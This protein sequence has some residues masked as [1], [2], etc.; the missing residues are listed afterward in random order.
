ML[1]DVVVD[2]KVAINKIKMRNKIVEFNL[3]Y[4]RF[5]LPAKR[6]ANKQNYMKVVVDAS[7]L[8]KAEPSLPMALTSETLKEMVQEISKCFEIDDQGQLLIDQNRIDP[9]AVS[10]KE[11]QL[12]NFTNKE[13]EENESN[14]LKVKQLERVLLRNPAAKS[15]LTKAAKIFNKIH[16]LLIIYKKEQI[17][18]EDATNALT[19]Y[20]HYNMS[21]IVELKNLSQSNDKKINLEFSEGECRNYFG[22][23]GSEE[24]CRFFNKKLSMFNGN[25]VIPIA[26]KMHR[27]ELIEFEKKGVVFYYSKALDL[28]QKYLANRKFL[29][30]YKKY[31]K[32]LEKIAPS[33]ILKQAVSLENQWF[34][35]IVYL[36]K[37][38]VN[39]KV[40]LWNARNYVEYKLKVSKEYSAT[41]LVPKLRDIFAE[42]LLKS[43]FFVSDQNE[44]LS[45]RY[46]FKSIPD[47]INKLVAMKIDQKQQ[48][49]KSN[50]KRVSQ[51]DRSP[52]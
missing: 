1:R 4:D 40:S 3:Y 42:V 10:V 17:V 23:R 51:L 45:L 34:H 36:N 31:K 49:S 6:D 26:Q 38:K 5:G 30:A 44:K 14:K 11:T 7:K 52:G 43:L 18:G 28:I 48:A 16:Y 25:V 24:V 33:L 13:R 20:E 39:F 8:K 15:V 37:A 47:K 35:A 19:N 2:D 41:Y 32:E 12:I 27:N 21:Y 9:S 50:I 22:T 29:V 46:N